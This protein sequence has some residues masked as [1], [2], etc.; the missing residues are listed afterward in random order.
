MDKKILVRLGGLLLIFVLI[1]SFFGIIKPSFID[2]KDSNQNK[3]TNL[4]KIAIVNEDNGTTYNGETVN[5]ANTLIK[6]FIMLK[7]LQEILQKKDLK[8]THTN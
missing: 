7:K 1:I 5:I 6:S 8:I 4:L 2:N 3:N